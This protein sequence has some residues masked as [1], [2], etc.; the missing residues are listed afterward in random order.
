MKHGHLYCE[1]CEIDFE[2][3]YGEVGKDFIEAYH[4]KQPVSDMVG[5]N[6]TKIGDLVML[7]PNCHSMVHQLKLY[8]VKI[9]KLQKILKEKPQC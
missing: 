6:S 4:N 9:D 2:N 7:C 3:I 1:I 8:H 5:N